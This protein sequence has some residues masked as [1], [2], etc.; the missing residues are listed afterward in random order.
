MDA[1]FLKYIKAKK[2]RLGLIPGSHLHTT[3]KLDLEIA[4]PI[5]RA[6]MLDKIEVTLD[7]P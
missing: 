7:Y 4:L 2:L 1:F 6:C 5:S 3:I